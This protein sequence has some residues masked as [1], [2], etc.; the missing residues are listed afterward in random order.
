MNGKKVLIVFA[1]ILFFISDLQAQEISIIISEAKEKNAT[2]FELE[3]EKANE[4]FTVN[5]NN[6]VFKF[7]LQDK[8]EGLYRLQLDKQHW[9][10]FLNDGKN[11]ELSTNY[12]NMTDSLKILESESNKFFYEFINLNKLY[13]TKTELLNIILTNYPDDNKYFRTTQNELLKVQNEYKKFVDVHSQ[14]QPNS[15]IA[16]YIKSAQLPV[17]NS[18]LSPNELV[19]YLKDHS[20]DNVDFNDSEMIYSDLYA[21]KSIEYLTYYR[22]QRLPKTDLEKEFMVAVDSL[23]NKAKVNEL[24]YQ[25]ITEYLIDGFTKFG[26]DVVINYIVDN[27]VIEDNL[28]LDAE[29]E[30]SIQKRIDQAKYLKI[31]DIV[32]NLILPD[33][34]GNE[35]DLNKIVAEK[36]LILF[37]ASWCPHCKTIMPKLKEIINA[38]SKGKLEILAISLDTEKEE[39]LNFIKENELS[40]LNVSDL[41]GWESQSTELYYIYA[42]PTMF[43]VDK[44]RRIL[45]KPLTVD[46]L[47]QS[48]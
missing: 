15:F 5:S 3:G 47:K 24:V 2:I 30:F 37:Y 18:H 45:A 33:N 38:Q 42:T 46:E 10:V 20:L 22:N 29:V 25:H 11:I 36:V 31:G 41:K 4:I 35:I 23:L 1:S 17:V 21:N 44:D 13:K 32:P 34:T 12:N 40:W 27:Y 26:F 48:I 28:C 16:R 9:L 8:H 7:S 39:W 6:S 19:E 14:N 43:L